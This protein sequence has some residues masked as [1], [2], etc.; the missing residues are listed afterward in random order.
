MTASLEHEAPHCLYTST[1]PPA[2]RVPLRGKARA[3]VAVIGAGYTGLSAALHLAEKGIAVTVL[4][5]HEPGWGAAGRNGGQVN[6]GLK[7]EPDK[8]ENDFGPIYG[9]RL[10]KLVGEA[11]DY[12]FKLIDRLQINCE[13]QRGGTL[14]VAQS[15]RHALP[16][17]QSIAQ[18]Q[19]RGVRL[20]HCDSKRVAANTGTPRYVAGVF[21]ARGGT[22]NPLGLARGLAAAAA[23]AGAIVYG[24]SRV[25]RVERG[26]AWRLVTA[27]GSLL[28]D[29]VIIATDGYSDSLWPGL[30]TSIVP[31]YSSL[32]ATEALPPVLAASIVPGG[33]AVYE[34]GDVTVYY[35][36]DC[37]DRLVIGGRGYQRR[38]NDR[39][40]YR[41]L[42]RYAEVLWPALA[43]IEWTHWWNGQ[44]ALTPDF[45]PRIHAPQRNI[46]IGLG[47]SGR[48]VAL[49]VSVGAQ[50]AAAVSGTPPDEMAVPTT[51]IPRIRFHFLWRT[52]VAYRIAYARMRER[53]LG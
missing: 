53:V 16:L 31:I 24:D 35:R 27:S 42:V 3:Q 48:G 41:H 17:Q 30:K 15:E 32:I 2:M 43:K 12:L 51:A 46:L 33:S 1:A 36:R 26:S 18:W 49:G 10:V 40:D 4:E 6:A 28:A 8:I 13:A 52:G 14:R 38:A 45:Y 11:P 21:D 9:P 23:K 7:H 50:L 20:E 37:N 25:L 39:N 47:Y 34:S 22:V 5:A 29:K 44:F 19:R